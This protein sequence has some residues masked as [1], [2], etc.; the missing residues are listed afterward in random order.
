MAVDVKKTSKY[1]NWKSDV[2]STTH[3]AQGHTFKKMV[4]QED[5]SYKEEGLNVSLHQ[6]YLMDLRMFFTS[7]SRVKSLENITIVGDKIMLK[8]MVFGDEPDTE[9]RELKIEPSIGYIYRI[10]DPDDK[11]V[12]IGKADDYITRLGRTY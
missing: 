2:T 7:V 10:I 6:V 12:Y 9:V 3:L 4:L 8:S 1:A 5:G 11:R